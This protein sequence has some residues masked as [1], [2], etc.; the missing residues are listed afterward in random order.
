MATET[1]RVS[2]LGLPNLKDLMP[3][4]NK[5]IQLED[6]EAKRELIRLCTR[7]KKRIGS[8]KYKRVNT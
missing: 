1:R 2:K 4:Y 7:D 6:D 8:L 5:C 3:V